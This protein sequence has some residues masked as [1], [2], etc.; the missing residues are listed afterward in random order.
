M[1]SL[2]R[3]NL[4]NHTGSIILLIIYLIIIFPRSV[5]TSPLTV[6]QCNKYS[7]DSFFHPITHQEQCNNYYTNNQYIC[8]PNSYITY[9]DKQKVGDLMQQSVTN[10]IISCPS[11]SSGIHFGVLIISSLNDYHS[12]KINQGMDITSVSQ[13][14]AKLYH[15]EWEIGTKECN[16]GVL[17]FMNVEDRYLYIST[18]T[19]LKTHYISDEYINH[20]LTPHIQP[21]L[22]EK[23]YAEAIIKIIEL[24]TDKAHESR[25]CQQSNNTQTQTTDWRIVV[26]IACGFFGCVLWTIT[27]SDCN[28]LDRMNNNYRHKGVSFQRKRNTRY[29][30]H[31]M[32][33]NYK[34]FRSRVQNV[35]NAYPKQQLKRDILNLKETSETM[36]T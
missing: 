19:F 20:Q 5:H 24:I 7:L 1:I 8:D 3:C 26:A 10:P 18:S 33:V 22:K 36:V 25:T 13:Y 17:I 29:S 11:H 6:E 15:K 2:I 14:Y 35:H 21:Y 32:N 27:N 23:Q 12:H 34:G 31:R 9:P 4:H 30:V 28:T 16:N